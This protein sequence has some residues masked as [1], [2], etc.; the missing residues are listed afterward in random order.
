MRLGE[1]DIPEPANDPATWDGLLRDVIGCLT[2]IRHTLADRGVTD[3]ELLKRCEALA[4]GVVLARLWCDVRPD[5]MRKDRLYIP[6]DIA[7]QNGLDLLLMRKALRLDSE[8]GCDGDARDA[9]CNCANMPNT[10]LRVVTPAFRATMC[11][12]VSR[13]GALLE[14][15]ARNGVLPDR[16]G[17][18]PRDLAGLRR[19]ALATLGLIR[20]RKFD[21]LT[22]RPKFSAWDLF[23]LRLRTHRL[24]PVK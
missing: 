8:R 14:G 16:V 21:T 24:E 12:L 3:E 20:R 1:W 23:W 7:R 11:E 22:R 2:P 13:T 9:S 17:V 4:A 5:V 10:G 19:E 6:G 18:L 15:D